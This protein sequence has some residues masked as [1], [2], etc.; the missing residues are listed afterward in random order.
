[1]TLEYWSSSPPPCAGITGAS[2]HAQ[3]SLT[4]LN[5]QNKFQQWIYHCTLSIWKILEPLLKKH[6][7]QIAFWKIVDIYKSSPYAVLYR[8]H[9][10]ESFP[11][12]ARKIT[13]HTQIH[14]LETLS[15]TWLASSRVGDITRALKPLFVGCFSCIKMGMLNANVFPDPVGAEAR[16]SRP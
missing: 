8:V 10:F 11:N 15:H 1:M 13:R 4:F 7:C 9:S 6:D 2:H 3:Q 12:L 16:S 5:E 14:S